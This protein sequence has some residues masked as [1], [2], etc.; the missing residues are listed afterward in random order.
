MYFVFEMRFGETPH[1][2]PYQGSKRQLAPLILSLVP[3]R[4]YSRLI[5]PFVG[6]GAVTLAAAKRRV[7][8]E[9][10]VG[11]SLEPLCG[12]WRQ[13]VDE[14][15]L[16]ADEYRDLWNCQIENPIGFFNK[17]R[18][19][20]NVDGKPSKLL[21]LLAR[22]VK[23]AV[24]FNPSGHFN[25]SPDKRRLGT[26]PKTMSSEIQAAH[27]LLHGRCKVRCA[28]YKDL[29]RQA[30]KSDIVYMD[31]PYQGTSE[32]RDSRYL[33][34]VPRQDLISAIEE[35]NE[36]GIQ[37][38]LSYDGACGDRTYGERLPDHL[39][40]KRIQVDAGRSSQATLNGKAART[41]ESL[42]VSSLLSRGIE[43]PEFVKPS[44]LQEQERLLFQH[45]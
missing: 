4:G 26:R 2:I 16:L 5:E 40:M 36:R 13:V 12:V 27:F 7:C 8:R 28:D 30:T 43:I 29:L 41:I 25:Q 22:C 14:P 44:F 23:N 33:R 45:G 10:L 32:G 11:D 37:F 19:E 20:F 17:V 1:P 18:Q 3:S 38:I 42:Y 24:R 21:F 6:S 31:P 39:R 15:S 34:G 9:F 35:L